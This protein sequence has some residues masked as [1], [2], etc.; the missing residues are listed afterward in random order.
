MSQ[1][2][3]SL[4]CQDCDKVLGN[5]AEATAHASRT[6]H[7]NF[8][9]STQEKIPLT[10]EEKAQQ[11]ERVKEKIAEKKS[12]REEKEKKD[13]IEKEKLRRK[14]GKETLHSKEY[15]QQLQAKKNAQEL[16]KKKFDD[17]IA[18]KRILEQIKK[19]KLD[20]ASSKDVNSGGNQMQTQPVEPIKAEATPKPYTGSEA[21]I[22]I[23]MDGG[24]VIRHT[25]K[26]DDSFKTLFDFVSKKR[27]IPHI[28]FELLNPVPPRQKYSL[29][30]YCDKS[31]KEAGLCPSASLIVK[32][33]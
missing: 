22:Q 8:A 27:S 31:L 20:R 6:Q 7:T 26:A 17:M 12:L 24:N 18:K 21:R 14:Q 10:A 19:D 11:L 16:R 4:V 32:D 28:Q 2:A 5:E 23:R 25:F 9:E 13:S 1:E 3:R 30:E 33:C 29:N 15:Y